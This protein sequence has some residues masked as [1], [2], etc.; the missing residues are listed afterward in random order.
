MQQPTASPDDDDFSSI[1]DDLSFV[2]PDSVDDLGLKDLALKKRQEAEARRR[3][4][5]AAS[6]AP[7]AAAA[8]AAAKA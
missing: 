4:Q 2:D 5:A 8:G 6:A 3:A 7:A 1:Y